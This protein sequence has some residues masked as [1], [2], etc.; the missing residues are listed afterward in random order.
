MPSP[1]TQNDTDHLLDLAAAG[2]VAAAERLLDRY[3]GRVKRMVQVR[4]D[5]RVA[6]RV[7]ASDVVQD[8]LTEAHRCLPEYVKTQPVA[9]YP[10]LRRIALNKLVDVQ[11]KHVHAAR[12]TVLREQDVAMGLSN[13]SAGDLFNRIVVSETGALQRLAKRELQHWQLIEHWTRLPQLDR[14]VLIMRFL[15]AD[16]GGR[17]CRGTR[18]YSGG[19]RYS[20]IPCSPS[21]T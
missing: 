2:D 17:G 18:L 11:R 13:E 8:V 7:D 19:H 6:K 4:M 9:F 15:G 10:W 16:V 1:S 20:S 5:S 21:P 12:R 3:R 14:D